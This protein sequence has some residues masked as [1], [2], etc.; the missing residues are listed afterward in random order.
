MK[1]KLILP[2]CLVIMCIVIIFA[3]YDKLF[4]KVKVNEHNRTQKT[5]YTEKD[6]SSSLPV[7][8]IGEEAVCGSYVEDDLEMKNSEKMSYTVNSVKKVSRITNIPQECDG[9]NPFVMPG[10]VPEEGYI[11]VMADVTIQNKADNDIEHCIGNSQISLNPKLHE[12]LGE[13]VCYSDFSKFTKKDYFFVNIKKGEAYHTKLLY[14]VGQEEI[15]DT[16]YLV[17]NPRGD[18]IGTDGAVAIK[19]DLKGATYEEDI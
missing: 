4:E 15:K 14:S 8:E 7:Y 18:G 2:V 11:F 10:G 5:T 9:E 19:I 16:M 12:G 6:T 3:L 1:K 17:V 13:M